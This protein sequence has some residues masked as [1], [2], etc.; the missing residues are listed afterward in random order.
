MLWQETLGRCS[1]QG[2]G[3]LQVDFGEI[4]NADNFANKALN[5]ERSSISDQ[6]KSPPVITVD[7][8]KKT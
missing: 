5:E 1:W 8:A 6:A 2:W 7:F 4:K 3:H